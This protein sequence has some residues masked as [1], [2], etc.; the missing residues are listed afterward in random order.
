MSQPV[1]QTDSAAVSPDGTPADPA[2]GHTNGAAADGTAAAASTDA[3]VADGA[4]DSDTAAGAASSSAATASD[5][6]AAAS[7][8]A[9]SED[10][11]EPAPKTVEDELAEM[12][13]DLKR[14][15]AEFANYRKR[16]DRERLNTIAFARAQVATD[17]LPIADDIDLAEQ[18]GDL[19]DGPLKA[20]ADKFR[21]V[22]TGLGVE[23]FGAAGDEF[24][25]EKHEA[26][27]DTSSGDTKA[28]G[29]V[30]RPGYVMGERVLRTAMVII[31]DPEA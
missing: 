25:P 30:L 24:D 19:T 14:V 23:K 18:H 3:T 20:F 1:D 28:L 22:L 8:E 13:E 10:A 9:S 11:A 4:A 6:D 16:A 27:Q 15:S 5:P 2:A 7:T 31:A 17:L 12:T 29:T 26:V 21:Q